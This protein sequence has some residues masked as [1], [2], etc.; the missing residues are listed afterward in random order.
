M[1]LYQCGIKKKDREDL[2]E[3]LAK[4]AKPTLPK[5]F[6][7]LVSLL[8]DITVEQYNR[9]PASFFGKLFTSRCRQKFSPLFTTQ[10]RTLE[11]VFVCKITLPLG[12]ISKSKKFNKTKQENIHFYLQ[13][14]LNRSLTHPWANCSRIGQWLEVPSQSQSSYIRLVGGTLCLHDNRW[15]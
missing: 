9:E 15:S 12:L 4:R 11:Y 14:Q 5:A 2:L 3:L 8:M 7:C 1:V 10:D 6:L 13:V